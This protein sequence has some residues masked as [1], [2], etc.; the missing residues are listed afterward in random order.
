MALRRRAA[1][2]RRLVALGSGRSSQTGAWA[3]SGRP[4]DGAGRRPAAAPA[5]AP[6]GEPAARA[7]RRRPRLLASTSRR[8]PRRRAA[9]GAP[10]GRDRPPHSR[11]PTPPG[12]LPPPPGTLGR[13]HRCANS[14]ELRVRPPL[15]RRVARSS[16]RCAGR[17]HPHRGRARRPRLRP[18]RALPPDPDESQAASTQAQGKGASE[19]RSMRHRPSSSALRPP[20]DGRVGG[21]RF[22]VVFVGSTDGRLALEHAAD[23]PRRG[24]RGPLQART[25]PSRRP[26]ACSGPSSRAAGAARR[27]RRR[28]RSGR[29]RRRAGEGAGRRRGRTP[30]WNALGRS[31]WPSG[32]APTPTPDAGVI[33]RIVG[34]TTQDSTR[35]LLTRPQR[36]DRR[37][38][39]S[40]PSAWRATGASTIGG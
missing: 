24:R 28:W 14:A 32:Q 10:A 17:R 8:V 13:L 39:P 38:A 3:R 34:P 21:K 18:R 19:R 40:R 9:S 5:Q 26:R 36:G 4:L 33:T 20:D 16:L 29:P 37:K 6:R 2:P 35:R 12:R 31:S 1:A 22:A 11:G 23:A 25:R 27:V 7:R 30:L 15:P